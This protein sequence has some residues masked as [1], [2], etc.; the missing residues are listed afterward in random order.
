LGQESYGVCFFNLKL[1]KLLHL[2][3]V[4]LLQVFQKALWVDNLRNRNYEVLL[5]INNQLRYRLLL[6]ALIFGCKF[7]V[8]QDVV[9][10]NEYVDFLL[11]ME[12]KERDVVGRQLLVYHENLLGIRPTQ[13]KLDLWLVCLLL[14]SLSDAT[15]FLL[16]LE[17]QLNVRIQDG[18]RLRP[19]SV[20]HML[21]F[22]FAWSLQRTLQS[23]L[24]L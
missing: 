12:L 8:G 18:L 17:L 22:F 21:H 19:I 9:L 23:L 16:H 3:V 20:L 14:L 15:S 6:L 7:K 2:S 10:A 24:G 5:V 13:I 1:V 11:L 4:E